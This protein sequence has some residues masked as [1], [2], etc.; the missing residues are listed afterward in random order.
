M[1]Y[2]FLVIAAAVSMFA[3]CQNKSIEMQEATLPDSTKIVSLNGALSE[4]VAGLGLENNVVGTDVTSQYPQSIANKPK[5]GHNRNLNA[6]G[7]LALQ[8]DVVIA[9]EKEVAE[10]L[11][12]QFKAAGI[13]LMLFNQEYTV[14]GTKSLIRRVG[15]SLMRTKQADSI[16]KQFDTE[17]ANVTTK[18]DTTKRPKVLFIYARGAGTMMVGGSGTQVEQVIKLAGGQNAVTDFAEYKPLTAESLVKANPD[19]IL[20]FDDGLES[21]GGEKGLL[22]VQGVSQTNA[23][24]NR[25]IVTM[26]GDLLTSFGPRLGQAITEL[27]AKIK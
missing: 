13:K 9:M 27:T 25:K 2:K 24:K 15:D 8:P 21:L 4:I 17:L 12:S 6:E 10:Q 19:V 22:A 26:P 23:A 16:I 11:V 14:D 3:A 20:L 5:V 18:V 7:I 1:K